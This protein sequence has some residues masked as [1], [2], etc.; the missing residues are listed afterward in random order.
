MMIKDSAPMSYQKIIVC[1]GMI[2]IE[3]KRIDESTKDDI[4]IKNESFTLWGKMIPTYDGDNWSYKIQ[5]YDESKVNE[6]IFPEENYKFDEMKNEYFFVGAYN[7]CGKCIG[8]AI[9][10]KDWL[11]YLY[12]EDLKVN[13][14]YRGHGIGEL[15]LDEGKKIAIENGYR[16]IYTI[17]QD[18][19]VS[20]CLFY[21]KSGFIIGG[22]NTQVY[23]GTNQANKS[24]IFFYLDTELTV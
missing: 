23:V 6:M 5:K 22:L 18:N 16:G 3:I 10:K 2:M 11:K 1:K 4:N 13:K 7:D 12:L 9:Y 24:N 21:I 15:L 19:N 20:A 17:G 8:L 14:E